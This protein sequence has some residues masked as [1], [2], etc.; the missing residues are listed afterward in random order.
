MCGFVYISPDSTQFDSNGNGRPAGFSMTVTYG[1]PSP[2]A[3][4]GCNGFPTPPW[5]FSATKKQQQAL[6]AD[7]HIKTQVIEH[8]RGW[9][10]FSE[11]NTHF[12]TPIVTKKVPEGNARSQ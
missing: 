3:P 2:P 10:P 9:N 11:K 1:S 4:S 5:C 12:V 8:A 6:K 7:G